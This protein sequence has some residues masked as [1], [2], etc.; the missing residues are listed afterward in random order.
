MGNMA[1]TSILRAEANS[2]QP[3]GRKLLPVGLACLALMGCDERYQPIFGADQI[4]WLLSVH[5]PQDDLGFAVGGR[6]VED[7]DP[8]FGV[9]MEY[10]GTN[11]TPSQLPEGTPLLNWVYGF[12]KTEVYAVGNGGTILR[13]DGSAWKKEISPTTSDLWGVWGAN[14]DD[15]WAVGGAGR[16]EGQETLLRRQNGVW[17]R[18]QLPELTKPR[19]WALFKVW[20]T[21]ADNVYAVGQRGA[22]L[23]FD[24]NSWTEELVGTSK[25][26]IALWGTGPNRI[27]MVGG[28]GNGQLVTWDGNKWNYYPLAPLPGL[29]GVWMRDDNTIHVVGEV[30]TVATVDFDS[31][32][33]QQEEE[34]YTSLDLHA[35]YGTGEGELLM[36]GGNFTQS[37][38]PFRGIA[39]ER[40]LGEGE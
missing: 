34:S 9:L 21:S 5:A 3:R 28:R 37:T 23:H 17:T 20:G 10:N 15:V 22:V 11:W 18:V 36:V 29:N 32:N 19:V 30:G 14:P 24:G 8:G 2:G 31:G 35:V 16:A 38:R 33:Y 13:F 40:D 12:S 26:L 39:L 7:Q 6:P 4:G 1:F 27:A 25:D